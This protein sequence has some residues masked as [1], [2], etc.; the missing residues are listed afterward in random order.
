VIKPKVSVVIPCYN[1]ENWIKETLISVFNQT[2]NNIEIIIIDD[3]SKDNTR[4]VLNK[5]ILDD[6]I[7]YF[8][9]ENKGPAS[10]RNLGIEK[11][12][13]KYIAF[14][15][16]DDIWINNKIETQVSFL[17]NNSCYQLVLTDL[18]II[19]E[20]GDLLFEKKNKLPI[21]RHKIIKNIFLGKITMYTPTILVRKKSIEKIGGFN[22]DLIHLEDHFMLMKFASEFNIYHLKDFLVK[23]R[24][25]SNSMSGKIQPKKILKHYKKFI[26]KS[27]NE[28]PFLYKYK[29][30]QLSKTY[31]I[32]G[33]KHMSYNN[34][35]KSLKFF[36]KSIKFDLFSFENYIYILLTVLPIKY[37][38]LISIK[39]YIKTKK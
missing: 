14:L 22:E 18:L 15:D 11:S 2:Y 33:K 23:R 20:K 17:E 36:L 4:K 39:K 12:T 16:S 27:L 3:G 13:G 6:K 38:K 8:N 5:Y 24:K 31:Q 25:T 30:L 19:D 7:K 32:V 1:S 26:N 9:Q 35:V 10:A 28:F 34:R 37:K 29:N 21:E